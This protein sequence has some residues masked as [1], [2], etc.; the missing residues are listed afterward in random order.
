[1]N[2]PKLKKLRA[3]GWKI[4]GAESFLRLVGKEAKLAER[5]ALPFMTRV[6]RGL[7]EADRGEFA[8]DEEV[9]AVF[10]KYNVDY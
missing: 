10:R 1:M 2:K 6:K 9:K 8:S 4:G 5:N 7:A 3:A